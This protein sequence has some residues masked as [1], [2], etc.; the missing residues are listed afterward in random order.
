MATT[1]TLPH[2][3]MSRTLRFNKCINVDVAPFISSTLLP[4]TLRY[5]RER[6]KLTKDELPASR[7]ARSE[8]NRPLGVMGFEMRLKVRRKTSVEGVER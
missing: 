1:Y 8:W 4:L 2:L 7:V 3:S 5:S 6:R